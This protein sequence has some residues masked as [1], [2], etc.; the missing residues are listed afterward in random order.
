M[1]VRRV[2][3]PSVS[4]CV[5]LE[6]QYRD[7]S[8]AERFEGRKKERETS[9]WAGEW[10]RRATISRRL[11]Q[12]A[13]LARTRRIASRRQGGLDGGAR[14]DESDVAHNVEST[15]RPTDGGEGLVDDVSDREGATGMSLPRRPASIPCSRL[16]P[17]RSR[18]RSAL[19]AARGKL[20]HG[21]T[22]QQPPLRDA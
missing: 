1:S 22:S 12:L 10:C 21:V 16:N 18:P 8:N 9:R 2:A 6:Q 15:R 4:S 17:P 7:A 20:G 19:P 13:Q 3:D 5:L 14:V 11:E